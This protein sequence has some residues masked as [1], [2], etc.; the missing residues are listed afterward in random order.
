M[1]NASECVGM[2]AECEL[3]QG[4]NRRLSK[5]KCTTMY[6]RVNSRNKK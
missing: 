6:V 2:M 3:V 5:D 1:T 4:V